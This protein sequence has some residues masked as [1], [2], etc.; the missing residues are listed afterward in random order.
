L[1]R[2]CHLNKNRWQIAKQIVLQPLECLSSIIKA[3]WHLIVLKQPKGNDDRRFLAVLRGNGYIVEG[4]DQ[5]SLEEDGASV[6]VGGQVHQV[7]QRVP[8]QDSV[9]GLSLR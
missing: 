8:V 4:L 7:G 6:H 3:K 5:V 9:M 1:P 2:N